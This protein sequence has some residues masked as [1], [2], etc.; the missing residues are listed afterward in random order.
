MHIYWHTPQ[1]NAKT[2]YKTISMPTVHVLSEKATS[3]QPH[4]SFVNE[5]ISIRHD[6]EKEMIGAFCI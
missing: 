5:Y 4:D 1:T 2:A 3:T 6:T